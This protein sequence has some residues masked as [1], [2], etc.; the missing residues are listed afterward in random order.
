MLKKQY[1]KKKVNIINHFKETDKN[2][3]KSKVNQKISKIINLELK[4][5]SQLF[6]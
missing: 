4:K 3:I 1:K 2:K 6:L 5:E